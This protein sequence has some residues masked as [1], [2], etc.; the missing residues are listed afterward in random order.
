MGE[1]AAIAMYQHRLQLCKDHYIEWFIEQTEHS[2][3]KFTCSPVKNGIRHRHLSWRGLGSA[4][5]DVLWQLGYPANGLYIRL[6]IDSEETTRTTRNALCARVP[7]VS[8]A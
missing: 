8:A 2:I 3:R 6:G 5:W 4:L 7:L 1:R